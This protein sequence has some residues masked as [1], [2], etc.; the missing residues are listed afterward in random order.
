MNK[1]S[2][3]LIAIS[4][5]VLILMAVFG[6]KNYLLFSFIL[7]ALTIGIYFV[8]FEHSSKNSR[9]IVFIA[10]ICALAVGGRVL[11][12]ALP[13]AK[14]ELFILIMGA[15]VSGPET[16]FLMGTIIALTSNMYFGQGAWT[17]W[18]MF[19]LGV[20]GLVS[21]LMSNKQIPRWILTIWGF[22]SGFIMGWIMDIYYI[23]GFVDPITW[24]SVGISIAGSFY[25]DLIHAIF[26]AVLLL[27][28]GKR[29]IKIFN[30]Y[31]KKYNL[32]ITKE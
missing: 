9:E 31:K 27:L 14:P 7:L 16:G 2:I 32:F 19:A 22:A 25:F 24:K 28:V 4:I 23:I 17:P 13:S 10:I 11:F 30:N 21:G 18:Q 29:W 20:I 1:K 6:S 8:K 26:T 3:L 12:A 5:V 15:I